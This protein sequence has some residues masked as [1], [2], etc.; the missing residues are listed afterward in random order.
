MVVRFDATTWS[1]T[2]KFTVKN[3]IYRI[4]DPAAI[5]TYSRILQQYI[6]Y[7]EI[8]KP[9][10]A[11][12][13]HVFAECIK[14]FQVVYMSVYK[15]QHLPQELY[16]SLHSVTKFSIQYVSVCDLNFSTMIFET[17]NIINHLSFRKNTHQRNCTLH[18]ALYGW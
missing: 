2:A 10:N 12:S 3:L 9:E 17:T 6:R 18:D 11:S 15:V 5:K 8:K 4:S 16:T 14:T 1:Q 7:C 13:I